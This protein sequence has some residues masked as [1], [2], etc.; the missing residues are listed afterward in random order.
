MSALWF[1]PVCD[2]LL[3]T[4]AK[5][6]A[7]YENGGVYA[8][9]KWCNLDGVL[10]DRPTCFIHKV[11]LKPIEV[12]HL[13]RIMEALAPKKSITADVRKLHEE[14]Q[15]R[16]RRMPANLRPRQSTDGKWIIDIAYYKE[17]LYDIYETLVRAKTGQTETMEDTIKKQKEAGKDLFEV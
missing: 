5:W 8:D 9:R 13:A 2:D 11:V 6:Y 1:V 4:I 10:V 15:V 16:F 14:M 3:L 17:D 12:Q 7:N